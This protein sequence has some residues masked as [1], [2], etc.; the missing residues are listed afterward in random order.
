L[1]ELCILIIPQYRAGT[2]DAPSDDDLAQR[3]ARFQTCCWVELTKAEG[4]DEDAPPP[5]SN[6]VA[7]VWPKRKRSVRGDVEL[8]S[9]LGQIAGG[10]QPALP[11]DLQGECAGG[12]MQALTMKQYLGAQF[13]AYQSDGFVQYGQGFAALW[14]KCFADGRYLRP[15]NI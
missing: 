4:L 12:Q 7:V 3:L 2:W 15:S 14:R 8:L 9:E 10:P 5:L 11:P 6:K 1:L 13:R